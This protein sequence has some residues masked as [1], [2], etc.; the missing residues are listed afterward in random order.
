M[1]ITIIQILLT[2]V[3][4]ILI[5]IYQKNKIINFLSPVVTCYALGI[6][7]ANIP[8]LDLN[9]QVSKLSTEASVP[10]AIPLLLFGTD[11]IRWFRLAKSTVISF[12][13]IVITVCIVSACVSLGFKD[14][15]ENYWQIAGMLVGVYTGGTPNMTAIGMGLGVEENVFILM[16][17]ADLLMGASYLLFILTIGI[18]LIGKILPEF[19]SSGNNDHEDVMTC[20]E[21]TNY[22]KKITNSALLLLMSGAILGISLGLNS[23]FFEKDQVAFIILVITTLGIAASFNSK[24][25]KYKGSYEVGQYLLLVFCVGIGSMAN[26]NELLNG[27]WL[28]VLFLGIVMI[29][30]IT[31]HIVLCKIFKIDRDTAIITSVAGIFGPPFVGP[32]AEQLKNR[33][34]VVSGLT[35]GLVGYAVGNYLGIAVAYLVKGF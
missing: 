14:V 6:I 4:P 11:F 26:I 23:L 35:S 7:I 2:V 29:L 32:V 20:W 12:V 3:A 17:G 28:Y 24:I 27:S 33:E 34:I 30:S 18:R 5:L 31:I 21:G 19:K 13:L 10:L 25:R 1:S 16:N 9:M 22:Q 15:L 8:G